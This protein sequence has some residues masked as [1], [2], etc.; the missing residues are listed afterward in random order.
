MEKSVG[1]YY[2][3]FYPRNAQDKAVVSCTKK[4]RC[5]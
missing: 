4:I 5:R 2:H 3:N 1:K